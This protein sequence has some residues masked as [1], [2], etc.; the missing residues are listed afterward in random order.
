MNTDKRKIKSGVG[1]LQEDEFGFHSLA[2]L[3]FPSFIR[4]Y[5]CASV[6][7][8]SLSVN[9]CAEVG[10]DCQGGF[11]GAFASLAYGAYA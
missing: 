11:L 1:K 6:V 7:P 3:N 4:V 9:L 2:V 5:P 8:V 10:E